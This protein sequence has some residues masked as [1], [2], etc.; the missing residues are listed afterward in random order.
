[1]ASGGGADDSRRQLLELAAERLA[2][3]ADARKAGGAGSN[4]EEGW[5]ESY[6]AAGQL[7]VCRCSRIAALAPA[8]FPMNVT[9]LHC[10]HSLPRRLPPLPAPDQPLWLVLSPSVPN[11]R[12]C[13][14]EGAAGSP[15]GALL[16]PLPLPPLPNADRHRTTAAQ[17][18]VHCTAGGGR[19]QADGGSLFKRRSACLV[20]LR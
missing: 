8:A 17:G 3:A 5:R 12:L 15:P 20:R 6:L 13:Q 1:M 14:G 9:V 16:H 2:G 10:R 19:L 11:R 4:C 7:V 18:A